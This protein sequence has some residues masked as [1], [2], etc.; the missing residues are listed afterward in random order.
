MKIIHTADLHLGSS[1]ESNLTSDKAKLR[2]NEIKQ[3]FFNLVE[4]AKEENVRAII[5][6]GDLFDQV[7]IPA[8]LKKYVLDVISRAKEINFY[9]LEGNHEHLPFDDIELPN[10][11]FIF[12]QDWTYFELDN[13]CICGKIIYEFNDQNLFDDLYLDKSKTNIVVLHGQI[14]KGN[15]ENTSYGIN[16]NLLKQKHI[17]YLALGHIHEFS[18]GKIDDR[19]TFAYCGALEGRGF[20]EC[21]EKGFIIIENA[22]DTI[23]PTFIHFSTR[24]H[25]EI[26]ADIS[27][28]ESESEVINKLQET[29]SAISKQ[30]LIKLTL[31]GSKSDALNL[32]INYIRTILNSEYFFVKVIDKTKIKIDLE[33]LS[34]D[35]SLKGEFIRMVINSSDLDEQT[36]NQMIELGIK[37]LDGEEI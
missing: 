12:G 32:D 25:H 18:Q 14:V 11:L 28:C 4:F 27:L 17:D 22:L 3:N 16:L 31:I 13:I 36:K 5:I 29:L 2:R 23:N 15:A 24:Q 6:A 33:K 37:A 7:K 8:N 19:G 1:L 34:G 26:F 21:D 20:D 9:F 35:L 10:N 30:D